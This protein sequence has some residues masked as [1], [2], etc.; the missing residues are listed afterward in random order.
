MIGLLQA[1]LNA[2][3]QSGDMLPSSGAAEC[4]GLHELGRA[5]SACSCAIKR[6]ALLGCYALR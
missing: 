5:R 4:A 1:G 6:L 2:L 3:T